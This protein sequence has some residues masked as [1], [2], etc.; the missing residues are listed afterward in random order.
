MPAG[1]MAKRERICWRSASLANCISFNFDD[2][3]TLGGPRLAQDTQFF[4]GLFGVC[5]LD[6]PGLDSVTVNAK[7]LNIRKQV[8]GS[9]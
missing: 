7:C 1:S 2:I 9:A 4:G 3:R 8:V 5:R 6:P